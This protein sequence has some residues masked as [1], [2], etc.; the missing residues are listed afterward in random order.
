MSK[1]LEAITRLNT[2][3][4][5]ATIPLSKEVLAK[6]ARLN[7]R[8]MER[9]LKFLKERLGAPLH[10][11]KRCNTYCYRNGSGERFEL[12]GIWFSKDELAALFSLRQLMGEIPEGALSSITEE[13][14]KRIEEVSLEE[15]QLPDNG[16]TKKVKVLPIGG[17]AVSNDVFRTTVDGLVHGR[18]L[19]ITQK[20][21]GKE[22]I[23]R[24]VSPLQIVRYRDNWYLDAW[25][26][27]REEFR[28]F[29]LSRIHDARTLDS[30]VVKKS[31]TAL[32][33]HFASSY[34]IFNGPADK[35]ATI[36]FSGI[37]AEEV[38]KERWHSAQTG[39]N[40]GGGIYELDVPYHKDIE[41]VMDIL[42]WGELAVV[43]EPEGL[44]EKVRKILESALKLY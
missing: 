26:H 13:L 12:P 15:G 16:W 6:K 30:K 37:A 3:L 14:W 44:R 36:R 34:G 42:R 40:M 32:R 2:V 1:T 25:C 23:S 27:L 19:Q 31:P 43:I 18:R 22:P 28:S 33:D 39:R 11:D 29:G 7:E 9:H 21:L 41:L 20:T 10:C 17:R 8:T 38:S 5:D 24:E 35:V 4:N